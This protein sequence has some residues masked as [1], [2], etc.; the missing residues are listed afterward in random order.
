MRFMVMKTKQTRQRNSFTTHVFL[1][2]S[3]LAVRSIKL[4]LTVQEK[5][6]LHRYQSAELGSEVE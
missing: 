4:T 3:F 5:Q 6:Y 1:H 2:H